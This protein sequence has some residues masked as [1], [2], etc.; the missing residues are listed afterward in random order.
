[1]PAKYSFTD[2]ARQRTQTVA[3]VPFAANTRQS[4]LM[5]RVGFA[6]ALHLVLK[7][8]LT[9]AGGDTGSFSPRMW[10]ILQ[11]VG[12]SLNLGAQSV[13]DISGFGLYVHNHTQDCAFGP[14]LGGSIATAATGI[15]NGSLNMSPGVFRAQ[16]AAPEVS[17]PF[18]MSWWVPISQNLGPNAT[19]GLIN[20]Q[21]QEV[22][23]SIDVLFGSVA[24]LFPAGSVVT[25]TTLAANL[26][27]SYVFFEVP[28]PQNVQWPPLL[29]HRLLE[30]KQPFG[31]TGDITYTI[32]PQGTLQRW[33]HTVLVNGALAQSGSAAGGDVTQLIVRVNKTDDYYRQT[34]EFS[35][36][37]ARKR[38]GNA[39]PEGVFIHDMFNAS[40]LVD[41]GVYR[42]NI[43]SEKIATLESI[44]TVNPAAVLGAGNNFIETWREIVQPLAY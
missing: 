1:M 34:P 9:R 37:L 28:N 39:L 38:Y 13:V 5:P 7:G 12:F 2:A 36:M 42:D 11:R 25:G 15:A 10:N 35:A 41:A 40:A 27:A 24:D 19:V 16:D 20:L 17:V 44:V 29:S 22:N 4:I 26:T 18:V 6:A 43:N 14:D 8:T 31:N 21:A 32:P 33:G 23:A 30:E 3:V